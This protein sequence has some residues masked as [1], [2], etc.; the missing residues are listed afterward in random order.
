MDRIVNN[1]RL[2]QN[3]IYVLRTL[4]TYNPTISFSKYV[5]MLIFLV[6]IVTKLCHLSGG[7][8]LIIDFFISKREIKQCHLATKLLLKKM[9]KLHDLKKKKKKGQ[10]FYTT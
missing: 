5:V 6:R 3:L 8:D 10:G 9:V 1:I 4:R 2:T 7:Q